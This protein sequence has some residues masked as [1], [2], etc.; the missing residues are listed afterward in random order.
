MASNTLNLPTEETLQ[1]IATALTNMQGNVSGVKGNEEVTYRTGQVNLTAANIG[2][3]PSNT[4]YVSSVNGGSGAVTGIATQQELDQV[5]DIAEGAGAAMSFANYASLVSDFNNAADDD[6]KLGQSIYINTL[7]VPDLWIYEVSNI[8]ILYYYTTDEAFTSTLSQQGYVQ[9]GYYKVAALET[10]KVDL[11]NYATLNTQQTFTNTKSFT[12]FSLINDY[13]NGKTLAS[14]LSDRYTKTEADAEFVD[15]SS[16]QTITGKKNIQNLYVSSR[17]DYNWNLTPEAGGA[18]LG[19][20]QGDTSKLKL[21]TASFS[22]SSDNSINLGYS[23]SLRW[24]NFYLA[25][26]INPNSSAFGLTLPDTTSYTANKEIATT[27]LT[28]NIINASDITNNTLTQAQYDLITNGKPTLITGTLLNL[29]NPILLPPMG[30]SY[31]RGKILG[32]SSSSIYVETLYNIDG[33]TLVIDLVDS[34]TKITFDSGNQRTSITNADLQGTVNKNNSGYGLILP[35]TSSYTANKEIATT[36]LTFNI[37]NASDI[38]NNTFTSDQITL[39][40]NGKQT[41]IQGDFL[42]MANPTIVSFMANN[43]TTPAWYRG[44]VVATNRNLSG[45]SQ[46][47]GYI[48]TI[49]VSSAGAASIS[50]EPKVC[51]DSAHIKTFN[52]KAVPAF[53]SSPTNPQVLTYGTDNTLSWQNHMTEWYG[54]QSEYDNLSSYDSNTIYNILES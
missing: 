38:S 26:S 53:P 44:I 32:C 14:Y 8:S 4:T 18:A 36:D 46:G 37:I 45:F 10:E 24:K 52:G 31:K 2:A 48:A 42:G 51:F 5:R 43:E 39:L 49:F 1:S 28:F 7:N 34:R 13:T 33:T 11:T 41:I 27:D 47:L 6:Y 16:D 20:R 15:L 22:P 25:G 23:S 19:F 54:T 35:S 30:T 17:N 29:T 3:L 40:R 12:D 9:I 21:Y 50:S